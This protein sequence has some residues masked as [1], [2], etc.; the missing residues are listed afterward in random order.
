MAISKVQYKSSS[1]ATPVVWMDTTDKTVTAGDMLNGI[2][3]LKNDGTTATGNIQNQTA[4]T[5]YP[6]T[7][8]QTIAS[9]KYL[10]GTQTVKGVLLTNLSAANIKKDVV[11]KVGDSV[12]DDRITAITGTY[13]GSGGGGGGSVTQDQDGFIVLP[14]TGGGGGSSYTLLTS[15]EF[16][17]NTDSTSNI[18]VGTISAG[19]SAYTSDKVLYVKIRD[20]AGQRADYFYGSDSFFA[21]PY[22]AISS[23]NTLS[24]RAILLYYTQTNGNVSIASNTYG[25]Y[26]YQ[27]TSSGT[28]TIYARYS[29]SSSHTINGT[30]K[31]DVY[32]L[33]WTDDISPFVAPLT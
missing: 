4:Q 31:C 22:P 32:L 18:T 33:D 25:V 8:D 6:S 3:A 24:V 14:P 15:T 5:I 17:V 2:T 16:T 29:S 1:S 9:G 10:S 28:I 21:N 23:T 20:K 11:V 27:V 7:S 12:D 26:A 13:E 19:A 30:F